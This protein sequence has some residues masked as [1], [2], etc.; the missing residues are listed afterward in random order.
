MLWTFSQSTGTIAIAGVGL[1]SL[2]G[3]GGCPQVVWM[4][5]IGSISLVSVYRRCQVC[6]CDGWSW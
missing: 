1:V 4:A 6:E 3:D 2:S 5:I